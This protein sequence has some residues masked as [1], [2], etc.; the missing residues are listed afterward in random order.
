MKRTGISADVYEMKRT[1][2][3]AEVYEEDWNIG[4]GL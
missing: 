4:R 3:L 2:I 1:E